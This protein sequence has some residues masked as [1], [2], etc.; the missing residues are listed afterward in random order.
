[1]IRSFRHKGLQLLFEQ[2]D[3][4]KLKADQ[5]DRLRLILSALN[6]AESVE[7]MNQ[8]TFRLHPLKGDRK[9]SWA[10]TVRANWRVTFRFSQGHTHD[11]DLED[12]H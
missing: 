7:D 11:I 9:G 5:L 6:A 2:D 3:G 12:Y 8:P 10:V 1:M 4:R